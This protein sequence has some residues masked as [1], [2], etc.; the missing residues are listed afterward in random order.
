[1]QHSLNY[2]SPSRAVV[3]L[4]S[5]LAC[6]LVALS[7]QASPEAKILRVDPRAAQDNGNPVLTTVVEVSQ[8]KRVSDAIG[9][10]GAL[11]GNGQLDCMSQNLEKPFAL[12]TPFPF[13]AANAIFTVTVD[14]TDVP[15]KFVSDAAWGDS[16]QQPGVGTAWL[17]LVDADRR[18]GKSFTDARQLAQQFVLSMGANDIVNVMFFNDRQVVK[19]SKWVTAAQ[20]ARAQSVINGT[21]E[22][23]PSSGRNRSLLTIIKTA[24]TDG[25]GALGNVGD[26]VAIPLHQAM[27]VLSDGFGGADP[28]TT[29]PGALQLQQYLTGGRFPEDNTALPKAPVPVISVWYPPGV[30][31]EFRQNSLEFMQNMANPDIGGFFSVMREGGGSRSNSIVSTVRQRFSKMHIVKWK[32][33]CVSPTVTQSFKLVFN[34]VKPPILGDN[35]FKDVPVGIDPTTWPLD[36]NIQYTQDMAK[37]QGG[38]YPGGQFKV[39]GDFCWGGEKGRAEVYFLPSGQPLPTALAGTDI[40]TAKRTQQQ[41]IAMGMKGTSLEASETFAQFE[42]PDKDKI[43][44]GSGEQA[45]V[46][47]VVYDNK[48][49]RTSGVTAATIIQLKGTTQP[50]PLLL[51]LCAALALVVIALLIIVIVRSGGKKRGGGGGPPAPV[52]GGGG[53]YGA[54][55]GGYGGYGAPPGQGYGP[56][57]GGYGPP[58]QGAAPAA[59]SPELMYGGAAPGQI[60]GG[61]APAPQAPPPNPYGPGTSSALLQCS[62]GVFTVL[63][64]QEMRAGRDAAQCGIA[65]AEPRISAVHATFKLESGQLMLRDEHSN[66]GTLVNNSRISPGVWAPV[67]NGSVV[68]LGPVEFTARVQ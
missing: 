59:V 46:R 11:T 20:K 63:Q 61:Q 7:A 33:S 44:A 14:G 58:R 62:A 17:I 5:L 66:N 42:A 10:C 39:Y 19:D 51:I 8:S 45:V 43:L 55:P 21:T 28:S 26:D 56:P 1:M 38:V 29:G 41:L 4:A 3:A 25:F 6:W 16:L 22:T 52:V 2:R 27:I 23:F 31:D 60:Y 50:L 49:H 48:A 24:A 64:G 13:P 57:P 15:A 34:N 18:M 65:L 36:V 35:T 32:A 9:E 68:R 37:S 53:G 47:L 54:P 40:D 30:V 12:Y 67:P